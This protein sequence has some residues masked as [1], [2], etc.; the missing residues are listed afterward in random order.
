MCLCFTHEVLAI[1][2]IYNV[3]HRTSFLEFYGLFK[4]CPFKRACDKCKQMSSGRHTFTAE[5]VLTFLDDN[6]DIPGAGED[7]EISDIEDELD[8]IDYTLEDSQGL[9]EVDEENETDFDDIHQIDVVGADRPCQGA[10]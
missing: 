1:L 8:E 5:E 3:P 9:E 4:L 6:F 7:S 2:F 10:G